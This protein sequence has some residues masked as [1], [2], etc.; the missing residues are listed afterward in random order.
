MNA[1]MKRGYAYK[2]AVIANGA[3]VGGEV[4]LREFAGG[5]VRIPSAWT[6][7]DLTFQAHHF[8]S[9][10]KPEDDTDAAPTFAKVRDKAGLLAEIAGIATGEAAWYEIPA[11]VMQAGVVKPVST[12][13]GS[14]A[15]VN[16]GAERVLIFFLKS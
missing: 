11:P 14:E 8:P 3:S 6:A 5:L 2:R 16:Q 15:A 13:T 7:A 12:N 4:D 1:T 9:S 10:Q